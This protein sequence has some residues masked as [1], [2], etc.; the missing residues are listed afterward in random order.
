MNGIGIAGSVEQLPDFLQKAGELLNPGGQVLF[1]SSDII[2]MFEKDEVDAGQVP[3]YG[4]VVFQ[5]EY[6]EVRSDPFSWL[7]I[8][9]CTL[10]KIAG[11][12]GYS[13]ELVRKGEH[14]DY[15]AKLTLAG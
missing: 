13:C 6:K 14:Y 5:V 9:F 8:D 3:Y 10:E 4:E 15:L 11:E 12:Q 2:Y 7:Y 1:D